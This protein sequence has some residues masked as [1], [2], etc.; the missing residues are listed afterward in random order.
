[1]ALVRRTYLKAKPFRTAVQA[2][3]VSIMPR[4][5]KPLHLHALMLELLLTQHNEVSIRFSTVGTSMMWKGGG[6]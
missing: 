5:L 6:Q 3:L 1:M 4:A 2:G